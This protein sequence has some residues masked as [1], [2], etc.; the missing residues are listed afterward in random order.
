MRTLGDSS[1]ILRMASTPFRLRQV[2]VHQHDIREALP[3]KLDCLPAV[4]RLA[5]DLEVAAG[6]AQIGHE[7][8]A[9]DFVVLDEQKP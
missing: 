1:W 6:P 4:W 3:G 9:E 8:V 7:A 2:Q 5:Y